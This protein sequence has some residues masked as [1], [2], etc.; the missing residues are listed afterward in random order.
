MSLDGPTEINDNNRG[1][2]TTK[3][4]TEN[5]AKLVSTVGDILNEIPNLIIT[6]HFKPTLDADNIA[7]LQTREAVLDYFKFLETFLDVS[8]RNVRHQNWWMG[9]ALPNTA[10]PSPHTVQDGKNFANFCKICTELMEENLKTPLLKHY[11]HLT[12]FRPR[13]HYRCHLASLDKGCGTCGTGRTILGLL[14]NNLISVCHNGFT[15]L[16]G[17]YKDYLNEHIEKMGE[18]LKVTDLRVFA[19]HSSS[20]ALYTPEE[21]AEYEYM[22]SAYS[23]DSLF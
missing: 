5:Y 6:P 14:P 3:K 19:N 4:F 7:T 17:E 12:L 1:K 15:D 2:G 20:K 11:Q 9:A 22:M 13:E 10:T 16:I 8:S 23:Q 21:Y 18:D